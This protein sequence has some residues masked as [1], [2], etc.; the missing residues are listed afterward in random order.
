MSYPMKLAPVTVSGVGGARL[1][2]EKWNKALGANVAES[3]ELAC[4]EKGES[5][6]VNGDFP[7]RRLPACLKKTLNFG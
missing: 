4:H 6:V 7:P 1:M 3:W 5:I 2:K